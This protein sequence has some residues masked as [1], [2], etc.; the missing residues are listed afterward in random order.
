MIP[1][2]EEEL[3]YIARLDADADAAL[4]RAELPGLREASLRTLAVACALLKAGAAGGLSLAEIAAVATRPLVG[5]EEEPSELERACA[6]A[7]AE[8]DA[9]SEEEPLGCAGPRGSCSGYCGSS[10]ER[11]FAAACVSVNAL[12]VDDAHCE[13]LVV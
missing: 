7:R 9:L 11:V 4:L 10:A 6:A 3:D 2:D 13:P 8:V 12:F 5:L 1:F